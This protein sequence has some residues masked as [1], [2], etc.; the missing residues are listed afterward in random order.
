MSNKN[1]ICLWFRVFDGHFNISCPSGQ[2][3]NGNF[4]SD[5]KH[6]DSKWNFEYCPYCGRKIIIRYRAS[7]NTT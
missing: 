1:N 7:K 6:K 5:K 4:K 3:A 2:R